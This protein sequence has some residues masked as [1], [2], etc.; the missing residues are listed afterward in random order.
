MNQDNNIYDKI[1]KENAE[2]IFLPLVESYLGSK[3]VYRKSLTAKIQSSIERE[4]DFIY[5]VK[6]EDG[7]NFLLHLEFQSSNDTNMIFRVAEYHGLLFKKFKLP[8]RHFVV[9]LGERPSTMISE[10]QPNQIF[11]KF[12]IINLCTINSDK[13]LSS[14]IPEE[15]ILA[16][17]SNYNKEQTEEILRSIIYKLKNAVKDKAL[18]QKYIQQLIFIS[19]LRKIDDKTIKILQSMPILID[20]ENDTLFKQGISQGKIEMI[21]Q[22]FKSGISLELLSKISGIAVDEISTILK[23]K[24]LL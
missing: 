3:L 9:Y 4:V 20:I 13:L 7:S 17:L 18:L 16:V 1:F 8:I 12:E 21:I 24:S 10:L 15:L 23:Q 5:E 6:L 11:T 14:Q 22:G 19:R 2:M